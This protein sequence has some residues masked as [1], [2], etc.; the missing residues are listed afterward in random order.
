MYK[1][2]YEEEKRLHSEKVEEFM[3]ALGGKKEQ[4]D[5]LKTLAEYRAKRRAYLKHFR[6][7]KLGLIKVCV[8]GNCVFALMHYILYS[9]CV[10]EGRERESLV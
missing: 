1:T 9:V 2:K 6:L 4:E 8:C 7:K 3:A 5:Y 10:N